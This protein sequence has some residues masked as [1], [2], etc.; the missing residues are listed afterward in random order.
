M[1]GITNQ[2]PSAMHL[3]FCNEVDH[4]HK[5]HLR[6]LWI[7]NHEHGNF[8]NIWLMSCSVP[9]NVKVNNTTVNQELEWLWKKAFMG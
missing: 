8:A 6:V 7:N 5:H 1:M 9:L 4:I 3:E 2:L